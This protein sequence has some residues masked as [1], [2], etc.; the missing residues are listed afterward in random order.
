MFLFPTVD[1]PP[2]IILPTPLK[3]QLQRLDYHLVHQGESSN[4]VHWP[5]VPLPSLLE[6]GLRGNSLSAGQSLD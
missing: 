6:P 3:I 2:M 4:S 1:I 5:F